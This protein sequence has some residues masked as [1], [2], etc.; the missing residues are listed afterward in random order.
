MAHEVSEEVRRQARLKHRAEHPLPN[1]QTLN[2]STP[3]LETNLPSDPPLNEEAR[4]R[5]PP[6]LEGWLTELELARELRKD[7]R[8]VQR[9]RRDRV[10]P[11]FT[12]IGKTPIYH[13]AAV[14]S[15]LDAG[16]IASRARSRARRRAR[17][18]A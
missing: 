17:A 15:W 11:E 16:G 2:K 14:I 7:L 8:T 6:L 5:A 10:G 12:L 9:W 18:A 4:A 3:D 13:P 1:Y